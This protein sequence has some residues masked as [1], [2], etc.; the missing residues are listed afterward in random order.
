[1][2]IICVRLRNRYRAS[3]RRHKQCI[4][5]TCTEEKQ[6]KKK[7][8]NREKNIEITSIKP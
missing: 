2:F 3:I 7:R 6:A 1:M 5:Q 8:T 4:L